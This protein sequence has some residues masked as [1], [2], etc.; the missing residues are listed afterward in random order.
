[1]K[2]SNIL[3]TSLLF[4]LWCFL[5]VFQYSSSHSVS[6]V[7]RENFESC[8]TTNVVRTYS[9]GNTT[10]TLEKPGDRY[11]VCGNKLHCL[12]GMKLK[13]TA[14]ANQSAAPA[15]APQAATTDSDQG[16]N[17]NNSG[18][19]RNPSSKSNKQIPSSTASFSRDGRVVYA[20]GLAFLGFVLNFHTILINV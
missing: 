15:G 3:Q 16:S 12:A 14:E 17:N 18:V 13:V 2:N 20:V 1:M 11:F 5:S 10:V 9:A 7:T 19:I 4:F 8:N 6:E